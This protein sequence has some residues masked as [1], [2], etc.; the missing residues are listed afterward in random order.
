[1]HPKDVIFEFNE[2]V[3]NGEFQINTDE[4]IIQG[5]SGD[6]SIDFNAS[7]RVVEAEVGT[8]SAYWIG[9]T[10]YIFDSAMDIFGDVFI[11]GDINQ[12]GNF[13]GNQIYGEMWNYTG[14]GTGWNFDIDDAGTYYNLTNLRT[15]NGGIHLNGFSF[16]DNAQADGGSN[17]VAQVD[18]HYKMDF[19]MSFAGVTAGGLYG[20]S[21]AHD[22]DPDTHRNCYARREAKTSVG[23]VSVTCIMD[24]A[25]GDKVVVMIENENGARDITIHTVNLN[26]VRIGNA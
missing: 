5:L 18:G 25:I 4:K 17:L 10:K 9:F 16:E 22:F 20:F 11:D 12:S 6:I 19:S 21:I 24:L 1:M 13:T 7:D 15:D 14:G 8:P 26:I 3:K 2:S 23:S